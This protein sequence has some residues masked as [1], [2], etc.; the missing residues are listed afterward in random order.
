M[1]KRKE[2]GFGLG[3]VMLVRAEYKEDRKY[4]EKN[5]VKIVGEVRFRVR[6]RAKARASAGSLWGGVSLYKVATTSLT[7]DVQGE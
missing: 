2:S 4:I 1:L 7:W 3:G 5:L 6:V